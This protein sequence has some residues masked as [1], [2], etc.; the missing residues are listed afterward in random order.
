MIALDVISECP[1]ATAPTLIFQDTA[2]LPLLPH[3]DQ[4]IS[5]KVSIP[6]RQ[7]NFQQNIPLGIRRLNCQE[8]VTS[9]MNLWMVQAGAAVAVTS[10]KI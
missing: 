5:D 10:H 8:A 9:E 7:G 4:E 2:D 1:V 3:A 6:G